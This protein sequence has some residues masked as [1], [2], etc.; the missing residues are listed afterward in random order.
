MNHFGENQGPLK[1]AKRFEE[2]LHSDLP[3][4]V[5]GANAVRD[6]LQSS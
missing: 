6:A 3:A 5:G 1:E 2:V 4:P